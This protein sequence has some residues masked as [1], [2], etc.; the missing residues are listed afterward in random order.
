[1]SRRNVGYIIHRLLTDQELRSHFAVDRFV[2]IA[3][4]HLL[5]FPLTPAEIDA[6]VQS[7]PG[8]WR[9]ETET[10]PGHVH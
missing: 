1:M 2:T 10:V 3:E 4:L 8:C 5:G 6:F 7:D 9:D